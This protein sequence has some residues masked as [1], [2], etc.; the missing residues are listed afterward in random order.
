LKFLWEIIRKRCGGLFSGQKKR[1]ELPL[2]GKKDARRGPFLRLV[3]SN[4]GSFKKFFSQSQNFVG[5]PQE[6]AVEAKM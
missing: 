3:R 6:S 5:S 1:A 2:D 4:G